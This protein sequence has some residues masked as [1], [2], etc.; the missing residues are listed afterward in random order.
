LVW[1]K[2]DPKEMQS[3]LHLR[4]IALGKILMNRTECKTSRVKIKKSMGATRP[5][6]K[7]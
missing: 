1:K 2:S 3:T 7:I 6:N 4:K 5:K